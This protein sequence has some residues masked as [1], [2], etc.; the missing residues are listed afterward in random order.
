MVA[1]SRS[2]P[3]Y[4]PEL[5]HLGLSLVAQSQTLAEPAS[6]AGFAATAR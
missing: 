5:G 1:A 3:Q 6:A 4:L 2:G